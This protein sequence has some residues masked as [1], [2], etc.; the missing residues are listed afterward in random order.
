MMIRYLSPLVMH[1]R[2]LVTTPN[3]DSLRAA[4]QQ[5]RRALHEYT[6]ALDEI[7][8]RHRA[9]VKAYAAAL[10]AEAAAS[11]AEAQELREA[12]AA[13]VGAEIGGQR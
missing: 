1:A 4:K 11:R 10:S 5:R 12:L 8:P 7:Q 13:L 2:Q 6:R 3:R 9:A